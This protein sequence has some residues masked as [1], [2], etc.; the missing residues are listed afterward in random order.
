[1]FGFSRLSLL[2]KTLLSTS[3]A[4]TLL[5]AVTV[6]I[7]QHH[8]V[9]ST[10]ESLEDEVRA[11]FQAYE[12]LWRAHAD[13]LASISVILSTMSD[14]R[15]A[16]TTGDEATIRD[17]AAELWNRV[18]E[19][20]AL[21]LVTDPNGD[22][23]T[24]LGG[25]LRTSMPRTMPLVQQASASFP[26]PSQGFLILEGRLYQVIVTPVYVQS[27][28]APGLIDVL[29]AGYE[30]N[31][32]TAGQLKEATGGSDFTF[33]AGSQ[34]VASTLAGGVSG[35][36]LAE[37]KRFSQRP[38]R[39][40]DG[41]TEYMALTTPLM[42]VRGH[43][44]GELA[45][46]RSFATADQ[47]LKSLRWNILFTWMAAVLAGL[48]LTYLLARRILAP[49]KQLD[50]AAEAIAQ[51]DYDIRL[52][53]ESRDELGR[54]TETFNNMCGSI[55]SARREL[56]HR[57]QIAT[58]GRLSTS[59]VHDLRNPLAAIYGGAEM[60][61]DSDLPPSQVKRLA[62]NIYRSSR[63]IQELLQDLVNVSRGK[64][65]A[66]EVCRL[67]D[68]IGA[69]WDVLAGLA[70]TQSVTVSLD[71]PEDIELPFE[72]SRMERVFV[73]LFNNSLDAMPDGGRI[74]V[75][76]WHDESGVLVEVVD[77]G[78]GISTEIRASLFQ[79]FHSSKRNGL[80]LGL[81]LS[82]QTVLDH[83]GDM[84]ADG[85]GSGGARF[86]LRL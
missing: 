34:V 1:M 36:A 18:S 61:V 20:N 74:E 54:L 58:I 8:V 86:C 38:G 5:F 11:S 10:S 57:E 7:V 35:T 48:A 31:N 66:V 49:V 21:F 76:A 53:V 75:A 14:V 29:V 6:W 16:F 2:W 59:I 22:V 62:Q 17:T 81:A 68:V 19:D 77:T 27:V 64:P 63:R 32:L 73:N 41:R 79:P 45:I 56:I 30:V 85:D 47:R 3:V 25:N 55:Q 70:E 80:G 52:P 23:I 51:G 12:S 43:P 4:I 39:I 13:K 50:R 82:R 33:V 44:I 24:S 40:T 83:G 60:L 71:V 26:R 67:R 42:D 28:G 72:R 78:P 84:W 15:A 69:A 37:A 46:F 65:K 9:Q